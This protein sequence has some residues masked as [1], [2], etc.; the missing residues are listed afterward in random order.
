MIKISSKD[1]CNLDSF[2]LQWRWT[3][4]SHILFSNEALKTI[5]P[6][7]EYKASELHKFLNSISENN[8]SNNKEEIDAESLTL[9]TWLNN[10]I[11][12]NEII[13]LS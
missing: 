3:Q 6:L 13:L 4:N 1:K 9:E 10:H 2:S 11:S 5:E 12:T 8:Q 7:L